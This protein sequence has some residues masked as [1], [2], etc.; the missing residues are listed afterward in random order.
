MEGIFSDGQLLHRQSCDIQPNSTTVRWIQLKNF[1]FFPFHCGSHITLTPAGWA[2]GTLWNLAF[3]NVSQSSP[4]QHEHLVSR[5]SVKAGSLVLTIANSW[6]ACLQ[7]N[8]NKTILC[9]NNLT[10]SLLRL[11]QLSQP[12]HIAIPSDWGAVGCVSDDSKQLSLI[13]SL[14]WLHSYL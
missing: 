7:R 13:S 6:L 4:A 9:L 5:I 10:K 1:S 11:F 14:A 8:E 2:Q 12:V 3:V